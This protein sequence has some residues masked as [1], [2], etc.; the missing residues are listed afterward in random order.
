MTVK[1][2]SG[3][4]GE[5]AAARYLCEHGYEIVRRNYRTRVS[6]TDI[7]AKDGDVLC[8]IEVKTRKNKS[9]GSGAEYVDYKKKEKMIL[10]ARSFLAYDRSGCDIRFDGVEVYGSGMPS[11]VCVNEINVIKNAC[12]V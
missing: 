1:N 4:L 3:K 9:F 5:E 2:I 12:D 11:G 8:F 6:E 10:A 7:I